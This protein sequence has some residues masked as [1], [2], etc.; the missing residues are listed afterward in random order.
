LTFENDFPV[1]Q[2][3]VIINYRR[4][5][6]QILLTRPL[7]PCGLQ[8]DF[9]FTGVSNRGVGSIEGAI[10]GRFRGLAEQQSSGKHRQQCTLQK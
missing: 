7:R 2:K 10:G 6:K 8:F 4:C 5:D 9:N 1:F 3:T